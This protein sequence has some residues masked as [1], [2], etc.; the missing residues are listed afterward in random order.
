M[1]FSASMA[2]KDVLNLDD[3]MNAVTRA[4]KPGRIFLSQQRRSRAKSLKGF[5]MLG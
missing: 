4:L 3:Q 5:G 1:A 2:Q